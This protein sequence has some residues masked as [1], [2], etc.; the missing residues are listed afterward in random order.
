MNYRSKKRLKK[1]I[2]KALVF[3]LFF[4]FAVGFIYFSNGD[5]S[6]SLVSKSEKK[7]STVFEKELQK[8]NIRPMP[9]ILE[10][11]GIYQ[12]LSNSSSEEDEEI[13]L[14]DAMKINQIT[15]VGRA[16]GTGP[17]TQVE[18]GEEIPSVPAPGEDYSDTDNYVRTFDI[19]QYN[20]NVQIVPNTDKDG[21]TDA[22]TFKGGIVKVKATLPNQGENPGLT[23][24]EDA[25]MQNV[26][27]SDDGTVLYAEYQIPDTQTS[28]P[29]VQ[30]LTFTYKIGGQ[31]V[32]VTED[33][34]PIFEVWMDGNSPDN[35]ESLASS[36]S[37]QDTIYDPIQISA[38]SGV[39]VKL[40]KGDLTQRWTYVDP[41]TG[42]PTNGYYLNYGI[43]IGVA[44]DEA[45]I[46]DLRG[47]EFPTGSFS[48]DLKLDYTVNNISITED[49]EG[50]LGSANGTFLVGYSLNGEKNSLYWPRDSIKTS[51]LPYGNRDLYPDDIERTV[52]D[53]GEIMAVQG[54]DVIT[55]TF[56]NFKFDGIFPTENTSG[57]AFAD[58][59]QGYFAV[60]NIEL[61]SPFYEEI[62]DVAEYQLKINATNIV[63]DSPS[64][65]QVVIGDEDGT[66]AD[67]V[68]SDNSL[69][70][71]LTRNLSADV[72]YSLTLQGYNDGHSTG[73]I[74]SSSLQ[75][76]GIRSLGDEFIATSNFNAYD[77]PFEGGTQR[78]I[79]WNSKFFSLKKYNND[80]WYHITESSGLDLPYTS[81]E[82]IKVKYG[83][84]KGNRNLGI[85]DDA[86][87]NEAVYDDFSWYDTPQEAKENGTI[88]AVY[89]NDPDYRGYRNSRNI[90]LRFEVVRNEENIGNT[91]II[92]HKVKL[93]KDENREE[94]FDLYGD[95]YNKTIYADNGSI[96]SQHTPRNAGNTILIVENKAN[97]SNSV[98]DLGLDNTP[99]R[100]YDV[101]D[102][103]IH[104][105]ITPT[106]TNER[107]PS[108][109]D[110][111]LETVTVTNYLPAGLTYKQ[112]SAN[113]EPKSVSVDPDTQITT[114]VWE[115]HNWQ[116]NRSA[117][118]YDTITFTALIDSSLSNNTQLENKSVI[119]TEN[120]LRNEAAFRT[121]T[122]GV[123]ISNLTSLQATKSIEKSVV[124]A[125][126]YINT[127]LTIENSSEV[128]LKNVRALEILPY[129]GDANGSNFEGTYQVQIGDISKGQ[130]LYYTTVPVGLL[131]SEAGV[132]RDDYDKL[133]P[134]NIDLDKMSNVWIEI[135][136]TNTL[137]PKEATAILMV[138][139]AIER[140]DSTSVGYQIIPTDNSAESKYVVSANVIATGFPT[141]LKSNI[142]V[143]V[144]VQ[145]I[146]SG[147]VWNDANEDGLM[148]TYEGKVSNIKV[149]LIDANTEEAVTDVSGN[150]VAPVYTD[151]NGNYSF[152]G[153]VK[154]IYKVRFTLPD[155]T[156]VTL[157][158]IGTDK[159]VNSKVNLELDSQ[160]RS[161]TD[162]LT[163]LNLAP[164]DPLEEENFINLGVVGET[165]KVYVNYLEKGSNTPLSE[166]EEISGLIGTEFD[167]SSLEKNIPNYQRTE[168]DF[169]KTG[170]FSESPQ[171]VNIYYEKIPA[172]VTV[173]HVLVHSDS[174]ETLISSE[175]LTG[176]VGDPYVTKRLENTNYQPCPSKGEPSNA[177]GYFT[178]DAQE[179]VYYYEKIPAGTV[180][181]RYVKKESTENGDVLVQ[182]ASPVILNGY[183]GDTFTTERIT[184]DGYQI[185]TEEAE[186]SGTGTFSAEAQEII[187]Y[188]A[189]PVSGNV[190]VEYYLK[191]VDNEGNLIE[192]ASTRLL[193]STVLKGD[194]GDPYQAVRK[195][196][197]HYRAV[198]PEPTNAT[199]KFTATTQVVKYY[200]EAIPQGKLTVKHLDENGNNMKIKNASGQY[201]EVQPTTTEADIGTGYVLN[202]LT[203]EG[204]SVDINP[205]NR[206]GTYTEEP[207]TVTFTYK[208]NSYDYRI[209]YYF[210]N[211]GDDLYTIDSS[212]TQTG[213]AK[214]QDI[215]SEY[216]KKE[217][218]G[219]TFNRVEGAPLTISAQPNNNVIKIYYDR[220][221]YNY[222]VEYYYED[223]NGNMKL[224]N[225][226]SYNKDVRYGTVIDNVT[227]GLVTG[228]Y[229]LKDEG[230]PLTVSLEENKNLIKVYYA[231]QDAE[232]I[233]QYIDQDTGLEIEDS[234]SISGKVGASYD[235]RNL[236]KD[237]EGYK[238]VADTDNLKSVFVEDKENNNT[239]HVI[240]YYR[241]SGK[242]ITQYVEQ[243]ERIK[244][245]DDGNVLIDEETGEPVTELVDVEISD[246]TVV[247]EVIGEEVQVSPKNIKNY[248]LIDGQ[249]A[250][251][252]V[253]TE[254]DTIVKY[255]YEKHVEEVLVP[256]TLKNDSN[257]W[258]IISIGSMVAGVG[259]VVYGKRKKSQN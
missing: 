213:K 158:E 254:E 220:N 174:S 94:L 250:K 143:G 190:I 153:L 177:N 195:N 255:Y 12:S 129:N 87:V 57:G 53:S 167:I 17:F 110:S 249:E 77:G 11:N 36:V 240:Y 28:C 219:F 10:S 116:V 160:R 26:S 179:V 105:S 161:L 237:I 93:W 134:A 102:G 217:I 256:D 22:S 132:S 31:V 258:L 91:G 144:V 128:Q 184:I 33:Q 142:E 224:N 88:A 61:F 73:L 63:Y 21:V 30:S 135:V 68:A 186:P 24:E 13:D 164:T 101:E 238:Y 187:Y 185:D 51:S 126:E 154:G 199:G 183:V 39:N 233:V 232:V 218:D 214:Y 8:S 98:T 162:S 252:V 58:G 32:P 124:E 173:K 181:V 15:I 9:S 193:E 46:T 6:A 159:E 37:I 204:Y 56:N 82:N 230:L 25:W 50:S 86:L 117:P 248:R 148:G 34:R 203:V 115:Y 140:R 194:I 74:E 152:R 99:R 52:Y 243:Q 131:E 149:E 89:M 197:D 109:A 108:D 84:Y 18:E 246:S 66:V 45:G 67:V 59:K 175:L 157:K 54:K 225:D 189:K 257:L 79:V 133:N 247:E 112:G 75:G 215:V 229:Y 207:I 211:T 165:G 176:N 242:V 168:D 23:W 188:Y 76:D 1:G 182:L 41:N 5:V 209:E 70:Y 127:T 206:R 228:F 92:R 3:L 234:E 191:K 64:E 202:A 136:D 16:T 210:Q 20:L 14:K 163:K 42:V 138:Q 147:T 40:T 226:I 166:K 196:I 97:V 55:I 96:Q 259:A 44:Q 122:Y 49:S 72:S 139:D 27:I 43:A 19:V 62:E 106:L 90:S 150:V 172:G 100:N 205:D 118:D 130:K 85:T 121:A 222:R 60:G 169:V 141:V 145:R 198:E 29:N 251:S 253:T 103:E 192:D 151:E 235:V 38:K 114:I 178:E 216:E 35:E 65:G 208:R 223:L 48:V 80:K 201:E 137:L 78:I 69:I 71:S 113:M 47:L 171:E 120:D 123:L 212:L 125:N 155:H 104:F 81:Q 227:D 119:Y 7:L 4:S 95:N 170:V 241:K 83:V 111:Y 2:K 180:T 245:D 239:I 107:T 156:H 146:V 236:K 244:K 231:R 200:Y 221:L